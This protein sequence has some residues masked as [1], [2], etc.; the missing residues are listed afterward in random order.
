M[1]RRIFLEAK[2]DCSYRNYH[3]TETGNFGGTSQK[4]RIWYWGF[5]F[6]FST[7]TNKILEDAT[8][9]K[10]KV[11]DLRINKWTLLEEV[12]VKLF[13]LGID[14]EPKLVK[15]YAYFGPW[16]NTKGRTII[17]RIQACL[18]IDIW[19]FE[20]HTTH[21]TW[22]GIELDNIIPPTHHT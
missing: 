17:Q 11:H 1:K 16:D 22:H 12:Q 10:I 9:I 2:L 6:L 15:V 18:C 20:R 4:F 13:N 7:C 8:I 14:E 5:H 3:L 19:G 21:I